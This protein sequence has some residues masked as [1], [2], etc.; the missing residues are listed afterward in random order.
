MQLDVRRRRDVQPLERDDPSGWPFGGEDQL[1]R[2]TFRGEPDEVVAFGDYTTDVPMLAW[3]GLAVA[4]ANAR[5][6]AR[7][8]FTVHYFG[9]VSADPSI[10]AGPNW[11]EPSRAGY[12][13]PNTPVGGSS[14]GSL[15]ESVDVHTWLLDRGIEHEIYRSDR[16]SKTLAD[17][18]AALGLSASEVVTVSVFETRRGPVLA[19]ATLEDEPETTAVAAAAG[20]FSALRA[21]PGPAPTAAAWTR[22]FPAPTAAPA[23][24]SFNAAARPMPLA[25]AR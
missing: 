21:T 3:A 17:L 19:L 8:I 10:A 18:C 25:R 15:R 5:N 2:I 20:S 14:E 6:A 7:I 22:S 24:A 23:R 4:T 1:F 16:R 9:R 12:K 11:L 13:R